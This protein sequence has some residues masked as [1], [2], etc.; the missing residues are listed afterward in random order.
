MKTIAITSMD[1]TYYSRIGRSMLRSYK[2]YWSD[3]FPLYCYNE[4]EFDLKVKTIRSLGWNLGTEYEQFQQRHTN[5]KVQ[6]FAKKG[7]SIIHAMENLD[8]DRLIWLDADIIVTKAIPMQL[9]EFITGKAILSTHFS[10]WHQWPTESG[11]PRLAHSCE[12][13]FFILNKRH[14]GFEDF[15]NTY[16][17]IYVNDKNQDIRRF[18]DGEVY[19]KTVELMQEQGHK[20]QNLNPGRHKTP[21]SRSVMAPYITHHKA[22]LKDSFSEENVAEFLGPEDDNEI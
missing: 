2:K 7:F 12:T 13:G 9:I 4:G 11:D 22:G 16:K 3:S 15:K 21:I 14:P 10:V 1:K 20:M 19:G 6:T 18:Y 17:D 8:F 5:S